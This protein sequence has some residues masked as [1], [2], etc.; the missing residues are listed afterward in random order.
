MDN[1][2]VCNA[3]RLSVV[4]RWAVVPTIQTQSVAEHSF[5][6]AWI[7]MWLVDKFELDYDYR[8]LAHVLLHDHDEATGGDIPAPNKGEPDYASADEF[9]CWLKLADILETSLFIYEEQQLGNTRLEEV[10]SHNRFRGE[11]WT[12]RL[13]EIRGWQ[14]SVSPLVLYKWLSYAH[15]EQQLFEIVTLGG[16]PHMRNVLEHGYTPS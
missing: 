3:R 15:L 9:R 16:E 12:K 8:R 7:Y 14:H 5:H 4:K 1:H 6:V 11:Q 13:C 10:L 2:I